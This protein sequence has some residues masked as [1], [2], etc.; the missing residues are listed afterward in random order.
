MNKNVKHF[1]SRKI[2]RSM[3]KHN[4][5]RVGFRKIN[6]LPNVNMPR[7]ELKTPFQE[8]WRNY[9]LVKRIKRGA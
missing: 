4:M 7:N 8:N 3:A 6:R 2:A 9:V 5:K 1:T